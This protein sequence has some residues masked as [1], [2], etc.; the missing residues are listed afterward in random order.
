MLSWNYYI[1]LCC[2]AWL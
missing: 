2:K 1:N